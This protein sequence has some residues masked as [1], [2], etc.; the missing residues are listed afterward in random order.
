[1]IAIIFLL[2]LNLKGSSVETIICQGKEETYNCSEFNGAD[3][4]VYDYS[5][6][7]NQT[8]VTIYEFDDSGTRN[9]YAPSDESNEEIVKAPRSVINTPV[10]IPYDPRFLFFQNK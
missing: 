1:M 10:F 7:Y 3:P 9:P 8:T 6:Q 4:N 5:E 2:F